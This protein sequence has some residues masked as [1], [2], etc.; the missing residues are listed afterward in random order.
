MKVSIITIAWNSEETIEDTIK[1]VLEQTYDNVEY[2]IIDG[3]ST[4]STMDI[5][6]KYQDKI[7]VVISEEDKGLYDAMNKGVKKATGDLIGI[8][9]SDD[10][11]SDNE[12]VS[13][14]VSSLNGAD[15]IYADLVYVNREDTDKVV[16]YWK[17][18]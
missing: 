9:N 12:V 15:G 16:R 4:D 8:L 14:I 5:V 1:S 3:K 18:G 7:S 10:I 6:A 11:Y 17:S 13:D 2:I